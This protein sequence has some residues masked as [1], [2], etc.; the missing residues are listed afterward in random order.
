MLLS[1]KLWEKQKPF[2]NIF[3]VRQGTALFLA[4]M[5]NRNYFTHTWPGCAEKIIPWQ[6]NFTPFSPN[7]IQSKTHRNPLVQ[8]SLVPNC[9]VLRIQFLIGLGCLCL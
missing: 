1:P 3:G 7:L 9:R 8:C 4:G 6:V 5:C 2:N